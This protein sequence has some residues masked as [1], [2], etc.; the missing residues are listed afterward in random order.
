MKDYKTSDLRNVVLVGHSACGKTILN[1]AMLFASGQVTRIGSIKDGSTVSDYHTEEIERQ[2]SIRTS[3]SHM[4]WKDKKINIL[5]T[6]GYMDF[7]GEIK[8]AIH[9]ADSAIIMING[10]SGIEIGTEFS[11]NYVRDQKMPAIISISMLDKEHTKFDEII[12]NLRERFSKKVLLIQFPVNAGLEFTSVVDILEKKLLTFDENGKVKREDIPAEYQEKADSLYEEFVEGIAESDDTLLEKFFEDGS[13][14]EEDIEKGFCTA[15]CGRNI[16]PVVC[17]AG[18]KSVGVSS[19]LDL[20]VKRYPNP[21]QG[22]EVVV[23]EGNDEKTITID[24]EGPISLQIFKSVHEQHV[25]DMSYFKVMGGSLTSGSDLKNVE[26]GESE[27]F[28]TIYVLNGKDKKD[29][30]VLAA[31]D[32]GATVKLKNTHVGNTLHASKESYV[33][34]AIKFKDPVIRAAI[35]TKNKGDDEKIGMGLSQVAEE[36]PTFHYVMD[37]ELK[38][39]IISGLGEIHL[40]VSMKKIKERYNIE[41]EMIEP[42]VPYRE[43]IRKTAT[44]RYRHKKQSGGAG[45]FGEVELRIE[46]L[47]R[48]TGIE[49]KSEL[50]G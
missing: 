33:Y 3:M 16:F 26:S 30:S 49:F 40:D 17:T 7:T 20:I 23:K 19:L 2:I 8:S 25:G 41:I 29:A 48:G 10:A 13:L 14:S 32:L 38:Q 46:P 15:I 42:R 47:P 6:P 37:A 36:D 28:G 18:Q 45:Q 1:D 31:G 43:T 39:T 11:W 50:V 4:E 22:G 5:D 34:S 24:P 12:E 21:L 27:R 9:V 44:A 35:I